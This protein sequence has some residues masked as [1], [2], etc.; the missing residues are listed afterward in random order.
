MKIST[1]KHKSPEE[2][3]VMANTTIP[4]AAEIWFKWLEWCALMGGLWFVYG[5]SHSLLVKAAAILSIG[6]FYMC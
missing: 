1:A 6:L 3:R 2:W 4:K 5:K